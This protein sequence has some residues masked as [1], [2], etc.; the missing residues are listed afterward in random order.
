[1]S[2]WDP[3]LELL[4]LLLFWWINDSV[5]PN[6]M[7]KQIKFVGT[8]ILFISPKVIFPMFKNKQKQ[9]ELRFRWVN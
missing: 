6:L 8:M 1:M 5:Y 4:H 3:V 9:K 2:S 7:Q